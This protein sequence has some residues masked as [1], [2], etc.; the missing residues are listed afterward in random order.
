M[1]SVQYYIGECVANDV[2]LTVKLDHPGDVEAWKPE[3][4]VA[5]PLAVWF[6]E[7]PHE[8]VLAVTDPHTAAAWADDD[9]DNTS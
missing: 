8:H 1:S 9:E 7:E 3:I 4:T 2:H 5:C 6:A